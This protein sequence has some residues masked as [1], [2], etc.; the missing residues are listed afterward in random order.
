M[1]LLLFVFGM[2]ILAGCQNPPNKQTLE[3][4]RKELDTGNLTEKYVYTAEEIGW[5]ARIPSDWE[6][7]TKRETNTR[8]E[9]GK[10]LIEDATNTEVSTSKL[11]DLINFKKDKDF[12]NFITNRWIRINFFNIFKAT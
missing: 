11:K 9:N 7:I 10:K 5:S 4:K 6:I 12:F 8:N 3:K 2:G 1:R